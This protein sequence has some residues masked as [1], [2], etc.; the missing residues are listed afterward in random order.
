MRNSLHGAAVRTHQNSVRSRLD[1]MKP[2]PAKVLMR[3]EPVR[4]GQNDDGKA[5]I[6]ALIEEARIAARLSQKEMQITAGANKGA[7][8]EALNGERGNYAVQWLWAQPDAFWIEFIR[9]VQER[10][11]LTP[12]TRRTVQAQRIGELVSLLVAGLQDREES[13]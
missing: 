3:S 13:A 7:Y 4:T 10:K 8:S 9:L 11:G 5:E 6:L 2:S 12:E 1:E